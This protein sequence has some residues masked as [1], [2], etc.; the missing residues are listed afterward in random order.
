MAVAI[1]ALE[2][3]AVKVDVSMAVDAVVEGGIGKV[4]VVG[5]TSKWQSRTGL[6]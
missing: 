5:T 1:W 3:G 6:V 4:G 2:P